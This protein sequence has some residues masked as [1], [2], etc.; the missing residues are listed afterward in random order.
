MTLEVQ[1]WI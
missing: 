1:I